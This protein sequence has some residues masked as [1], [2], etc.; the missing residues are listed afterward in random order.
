MHIVWPDALL[1]WPAAQSVQAVVEPLATVP[2]GHV[3]QSVCTPSTKKVPG[4]QQ[5][6][7][8]KLVHLAKVLFG[9]GV[10][11]EQ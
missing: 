1:Y 8:A 5:M 10:G 2:T 11:L 9:H 7:E 6:F 4:P 3:W